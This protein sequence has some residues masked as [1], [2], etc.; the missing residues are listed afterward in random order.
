MAYLL[1]TSGHQAGKS[2]QVRYNEIVA[3]RETNKEFQLLDPKV[4]RRHFKIRRAVNQ[5]IISELDTTN[6]VFV[7][8]TK[9][10]ESPLADGD[11][12]SVGETQILFIASDDQA[13]LEAAKR[14]QV[15]LPA[16]AMVT[17]VEQK[18]Q[19]N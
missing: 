18:N 1:I 9:V 10:N 13:A 16:A 6:G 8:G 12:I 2:V 11:R 3:G 14:S 19:R 5:F 4:S 15:S 17:V 7:N